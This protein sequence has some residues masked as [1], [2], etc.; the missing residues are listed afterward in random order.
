MSINSESMGANLQGGN[1]DARTE[2][3]RMLGSIKTERKTEAS[4]ANVAKAT[5]A[6]K[7]GRAHV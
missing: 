3:A 7:I 4:R 6:R 1:N 5:E 2:A